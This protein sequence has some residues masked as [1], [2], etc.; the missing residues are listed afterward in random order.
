M[1]DRPPV[2]EAPVEQPEQALENERHEA[3]IQF[4]ELLEPLVM[5]LG[6]VWLVLLLVELVWGATAFTQTLVWVIW[7]VFLVDFLTRFIIAP[8]KLDF[9]RANWLTTLS[10]FVPALRLFRLA[11]LAYLMR[12]TRTVRSMQLL[13][14]VSSL[15]RGMR[16]LRAHMRRRQ[17][18]YVILLTAIVLVVG[19][20]A[21]YFFE[22]NA[23]SG[24]FRSYWDSLYWTGMMLTTLGSAYWP[25]TGEG[26]VLT[27]LL[28]LYAFA[29]FG[30]LTATLATFFIGREAES[31][32]SELATLRT[33]Q[34]LR[35]EIA[36]QRAEIAALRDELRQS[37]E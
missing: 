36:A 30:Y 9:L 25:E 19:A 16:A 14:V 20:A 31:D 12:A 17:A 33:I 23:P 15:N 28:A 22:Q 8:R 10:L 27:L 7:A 3:L 37:G 5:A 11:K 4:S 35:E 13:R 29:V 1:T 2:G 18:G 26:R 6:F 24:G 21:M 34:S 32:E